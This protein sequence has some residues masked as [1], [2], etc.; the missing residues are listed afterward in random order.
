MERASAE[1]S[2]PGHLVSL[3]LSTA[4]A[5]CCTTIPTILWLC[6]HTLASTMLTTCLPKL[7]I[8]TT[9]ATY[10]LYTVHQI[11]TLMNIAIL[12]LTT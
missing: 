9:S 6:C 2:G 7:N 12:T 10:M 11:P 1:E 8:M 4:A 5:Q 3:G